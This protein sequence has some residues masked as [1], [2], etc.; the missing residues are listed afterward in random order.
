VVADQ[1]GGAVVSENQGND[2]KPSLAITIVS[3]NESLIIPCLDTLLRHPPANC[4]YRIYATW[5]GPG[6]GL[7]RMSPELVQR[8][9]QVAFTESFTG[10]F[11]F[12][13]NKMLERIDADYY[14]LAND[15]LLFLPGSVANAIEF[16]EL[17]ENA[18]IGQLGIK[19][20]NADGT[21]QPS[22]Y[23]FAGILRTV[24]AIS[25][26]RNFVPLS[27]RLFKLAELLGIGAGK[28]RYWNHDRVMEVDSFRGAYML[29]RKAALRDVGLLD[30][31]GGEET[32]WHMRFHKLGWKIVFYPGAEITHLGS[33][34][35]KVDP[36]SELIFVRAF[37]NIY[38]KHMS[39]LRYRI[40][41]FSFILIYLWR[42]LS[43]A[44]MGRVQRREISRKGLKLI[45]QWPNEIG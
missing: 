36:S 23:S 6:R 29:V 32:E 10:G 1:T 24:L 43:A 34:T 41:R 16:M 4:D 7:A 14:L 44:L 15:D 27:S 5:N 13:Q 28:S 30:V 25:G 35:T 8:F 18:R 20:L 17:P 39:R 12:N 21:L 40:I 22:T 26:L 9:P 31:K 37:L 11:P 33:M 3:S 38:F 19:L 45:M 42:W 2:R